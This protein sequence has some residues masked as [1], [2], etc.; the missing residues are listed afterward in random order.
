MT[1]TAT[2]TRVTVEAATTTSALSYPSERA[3]KPSR[4]EDIASL[5]AAVAAIRGVDE[6]PPELTDK[7]SSR[8]RSLNLSKPCSTSL[9]IPRCAGT[10][11]LPALA[12]DRQRSRRRAACG[13]TRHRRDHRQRP[14]SSPSMWCRVY[15]GLNDGQEPAIPSWTISRGWHRCHRARRPRDRGS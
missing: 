2:I 11:F 6:M 1:A 12:G 8:S 13:R 9:A 4:G 7:R 15:V 10:A 5:M 14:P 3:E